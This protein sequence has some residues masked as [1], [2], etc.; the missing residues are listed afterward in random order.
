MLEA[1]PALSIPDH[2]LTDA[3]LEAALVL[4]YR[5]SGMGIETELERVGRA[6]KR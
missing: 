1:D 4:A 6:A 3:M 5:V 2:R